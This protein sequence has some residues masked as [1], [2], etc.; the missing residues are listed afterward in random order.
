M[1]IC[2]SERYFKFL[3]FYI[4]PIM[5]FDINFKGYVESAMRPHLLI[6]SIRYI[7]Y[8]R[9]QIPQAYDILIKNI[10]NIRIKIKTESSL[11]KKNKYI[12][13]IRN[14][15]QFKE[16]LNLLFR[17]LINI[18]SSDYD[19][20]KLVMV[21]GNNP[22]AAKETYVWKFPKNKLRYNR[23]VSM[24]NCRRM[25]HHNLT[26]I[27]KEQD[28]VLSTGKV[29][30]YIYL[31][32]DRHFP[33]QHIDPHLKKPLMSFLQVMPDNFGLN[34]IGNRKIIHIEYN[35]DC[36]EAGSA[37]NSLIVSKEGGK[38]FEQLHISL[39]EPYNR[40]TEQGMVSF[41]SDEM[42][43]SYGGTKNIVEKIKIDQVETSSPPVHIDITDISKIV[44]YSYEWN[45][46]NMMISGF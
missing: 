15:E 26:C 12:K 19:L 39:S 8:S 22:S 13:F 45:K 24:G 17:I 3:I 4:K 28:T 25:I 37:D 10:E 36:E 7:L 30:F 32:R 5:K 46:I 42:N 33:S 20:S 16:K 21:L 18:W 40:D 6:E 27:E 38:M 1:T 43:D 41:T 35:Y 29:F 11:I 44:A 2:E 9:G 34:F 14:A 23:L 31:G